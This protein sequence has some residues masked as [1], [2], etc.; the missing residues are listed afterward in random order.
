MLFRNGNTHPKNEEL[1]LASHL[2]VEHQRKLPAP[3]S[4]VYFTV[5]I[6]TGLTDKLGVIPVKDLNFPYKALP[7]EKQNLHCISVLILSCSEMVFF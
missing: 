1:I 4:A 3:P 7:P 6:I 2:L 5:Q